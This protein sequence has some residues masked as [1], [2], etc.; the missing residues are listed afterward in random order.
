MDKYDTNCL[1][2]GV[3]RICSYNVIDGIANNWTIEIVRYTNDD[4]REW[5]YIIK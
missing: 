3:E 1:G 2:R 4:G 5:K